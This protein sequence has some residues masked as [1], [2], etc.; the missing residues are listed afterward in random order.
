MGLLLFLNIVLLN[1]R[2]SNHFFK[3]KKDALK[4][5]LG[6]SPA[7]N[8]Q[9]NSGKKMVN[10]GLNWK[11]WTLSVSR[12]IQL[13]NEKTWAVFHSEHFLL[14][15]PSLH[16]EDRNTNSKLLSA[17]LSRSSSTTR[18]YN[19]KWD[20]SDLGELPSNDI[21]IING[22]GWGQTVLKKNFNIYESIVVIQR[23]QSAVA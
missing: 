15:N 4:L 14:C 2:L 17:H 22:I 16:R 21:T 6:E 23:K 9:I 18:R 11:V 13:C 10:G 1:L 8:L 7:C 19:L 3:I 12:S 5:K 20:V